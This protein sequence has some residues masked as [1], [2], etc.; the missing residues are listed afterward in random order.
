MNK[1]I[2]VK[3]HSNLARDRNT[4]AIVNIN[5]GEMAQ[6]RK[7]KKLWRE[8]QDELSSLKSDVAYMKEMMAKLIEEKDGN[9]S[10]NS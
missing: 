7:R 2:K 1:Y 4:G 9:N 5:S 8:Q 10:N 6:A 3:G